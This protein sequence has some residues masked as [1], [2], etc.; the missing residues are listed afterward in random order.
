MKLIPTSPLTLQWTTPPT[1]HPL[2]NPTLNHPLQCLHA[3]ITQIHCFRASPIPHGC[4]TDILDQMA[5]WSPRN[6]HINE[7]IISVLCAERRDIG[8]SS[9]LPCTKCKLFS[10]LGKRGHAAPLMPR[11]KTR[12]Q[13]SMHSITGQLPKCHWRSTPPSAQCLLSLSWLIS[14]LSLLSWDF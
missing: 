6:S 5:T 8:P 1:P 3:P 4:M 12:R 10:F 2:A 13:P 14:P 7:T 11:W 9:A